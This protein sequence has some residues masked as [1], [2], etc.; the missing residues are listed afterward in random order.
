MQSLCTRQ[1]DFY[2][3]WLHLVKRMPIENH[4]NQSM[5]I[6]NINWTWFS[7][8]ERPSF[9][10]KSFFFEFKF[11]SCICYCHENWNCTLNLCILESKFKLVRT[12]RFYIWHSFRWWFFFSCITPF[13]EQLLSTQFRFNIHLDA[14]N[15]RVVNKCI[16]LKWTASLREKKKKVQY[17]ERPMSSLNVIN[18][19]KDNAS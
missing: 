19:L 2:V 4:L 17:F 12:F 6:N 10:S 9:V 8:F 16:Q 15:C 5:Q 18:G 1:E 11:R 14:I 3:Y 7:S 13:Q